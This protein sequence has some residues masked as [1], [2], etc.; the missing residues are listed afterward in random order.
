MLRRDFVAGG[1]LGLLPFVSRRKVE[2]NETEQVVAITSTEG[3]EFYELSEPIDVADVLNTVTFTGTC[4]GGLQLM[5]SDAIPGR[6]FNAMLTNKGRAY[7]P[8]NHWRRGNNWGCPKK[9]WR[10]MSEWPEEK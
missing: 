4:R 6:R 2:A 7:D 10:K 8:I 1:M 3:G 5:V 9:Y